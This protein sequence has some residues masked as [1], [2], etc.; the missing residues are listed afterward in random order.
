MKDAF[1]QFFSGTVSFRADG[2]FPERFMNLSERH[3]IRL[4]SVKR[5]DNGI[6]GKMPSS[7][8]RRI[9]PVAM[10]T[11]MR[12]R[13]TKKTGL[14]FIILPY[15]KR[16]G[17]PV[18][19]V[20]FILTVFLLSRFVW[21]ISF[22]D[23]DEALA[24]EIKEAAYN[25]GIR[26]GARRSFL[27]GQALS[28]RI[29][30]D[31]DGIS[32]AS[33]NIFGSNVTID[34]REY[35]KFISEINDNEPCNI[36]ASKPGII[37]EIHA[38]QGEACTEKGKIVDSGELLISGVIE[39]ASSTVSMVHAS[40][41]VLAR[42]DH[43][44]TKTVSFFQSEPLETGRIIKIRRMTLFDVELPLYIGKLPHGDFRKERTERPVTI[45][46]LTL[47]MTIINETWRETKVMEH[48]I[49]KKEA[50]KR[51]LEAVEKEIKALGDIRILSRSQYTENNGNNVTV[52]VDIS[53]L[54]DI[55]KE[56]T[57]KFN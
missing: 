57:I 24:A 21:I 31:V 28:N 20:L 27:D 34:V 13:I 9:R 2:D 42:T 51:A 1:T 38:L 5:T 16:P 53:A 4:F 18:G 54:E 14:P 36:V 10:R 7:D 49:S 30:L 55:A 52:T 35:E 45:G 50:E 32:W 25:A 41:T 47:P 56:Q 44:F 19:I 17:I 37:T 46:N 8:Y 39:D 48:C 3:G 22:P 15:R 23:V 29:E 43:R 6:T 11:G 26:P 33:V 40:G 12:V